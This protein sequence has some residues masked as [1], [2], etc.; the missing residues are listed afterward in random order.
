MQEVP[1]RPWIE[2]V[3]RVRFF[4]KDLFLFDIYTSTGRILPLSF[5]LSPVLMYLC[6]TLFSVFTRTLFPTS[7]ASCILRLVVLTHFVFIYFLKL[8]STFIYS[9]IFVLCDFVLK[10]AAQSKLHHY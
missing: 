9:A 3:R 6:L 8:I 7:T 2:R 1:A 4:L 10:S 5:S